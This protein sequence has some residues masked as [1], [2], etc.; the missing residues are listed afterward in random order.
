MPARIITARRLT[1]R[2]GRLSGAVLYGDTADGG[3]YFDLMQRGTDLSAARSTLIFGEAL[4]RLDEPTPPAATPTR[5]H[6]MNT[7]TPTL[8][9]GH[10]MVGHSFVERLVDHGLHQGGDGL[11]WLRGLGQAGAGF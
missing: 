1:L 10:G 6:S 3:W 4:C 7:S 2:D 9:V 11:R 5:S 8:V